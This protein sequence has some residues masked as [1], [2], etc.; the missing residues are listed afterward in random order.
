MLVLL[1]VGGDPVMA[2]KSK[3]DLFAAIRRDSRIENL[4]IRAL[5]DKY[6]VNR[7][8]KR[9]PVSAADSTMVLSRSVGIR[10]ARS[11]T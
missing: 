10:H 11:N 8:P 2:A 5:A 3:V 1:L 6:G 7:P 4:S 9:V